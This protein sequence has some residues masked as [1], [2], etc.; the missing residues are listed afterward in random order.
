MSSCPIKNMT[1]G[2]WYTIC[3]L[4]VTGTYSLEP[5][6]HTT[7][8]AHY[9][10]SW[11]LLWGSS[12]TGARHHASV[13]HYPQSVLSYFWNRKN[14]IARMEIISLISVLISTL[15]NSLTLVSAAGNQSPVEDEDAYYE[16]ADK[17]YPLTRINGPS[18]KNESSLCLLE[19]LI[20]IFSCFENTLI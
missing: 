20:L 12:S 13:H 10:A 9:S 14:Y 4:N 19:N 17:N 5:H 3:I 11:G 6:G 18:C 16:D 8:T 7:S 15:A 2:R 1:T